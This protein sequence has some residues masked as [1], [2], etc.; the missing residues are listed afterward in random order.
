MQVCEAVIVD[1]R[2]V[3]GTSAAASCLQKKAIYKAAHLCPGAWNPVSTNGK[4]STAV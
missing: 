4:K 1:A 2:P 3:L